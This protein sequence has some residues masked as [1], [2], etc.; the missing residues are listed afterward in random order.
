MAS[1]TVHQSNDSK[2]CFASIHNPRST[3]VSTS[4]SPFISWIGT[5]PTTG[6]SMPVLRS[7]KSD[8]GKHFEVIAVE[9]VDS[10]NAIRLHRGH[11]LQI[12]HV[13]AGD[14]MTPQQFH[15]TRDS[16]GRDW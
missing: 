10:L 15:P 6:I 7:H 14:G 3:A 4:S 9:R 12:E 1:A 11:N 8:L 16:S 2:Y 5:T 13:S